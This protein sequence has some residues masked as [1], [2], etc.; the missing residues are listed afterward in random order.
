VDATAARLRQLEEENMRL[1]A[2]LEA[3]QISSPKRLVIGGS[4]SRSPSHSTSPV[5]FSPVPTRSRARSNPSPTSSSPQG[6]PRSNSFGN[7]NGRSD[8]ENSASRPK[9]FARRTSFSSPQR[10]A[11]GPEEG[12]GFVNNPLGRGRGVLRRLL[13]DAKGQVVTPVGHGKLFEAA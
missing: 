12:Y 7:G 11:R 4:P 8:Q 3:A 9:F 10:F 13:G 2:E 6:L 1:R 5:P